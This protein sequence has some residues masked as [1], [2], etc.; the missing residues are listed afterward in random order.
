MW[1]IQEKAHGENMGDD[2]IAPDRKEF[3]SPEVVTRKRARENFIVVGFCSA[4]FDSFKKFVFVGKR[5]G[6]GFAA[7]HQKSCAR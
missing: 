5:G 1:P 6:E 7:G 3:D 4:L 2:G